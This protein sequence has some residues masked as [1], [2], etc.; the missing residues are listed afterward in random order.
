MIQRHQYAH[1]GVT[2]KADALDR[3]Q[4]WAMTTPVL[5]P[6]YF[7]HFLPKFDNLSEERLVGPLVDADPSA[8]LV[9]SKKH[10]GSLVMA[11]PFFSKNGCGNVYSRMGAV[12]LREHFRAVWGAVDADDVAS[13]AERGEAQFQAWWADSEARGLCYSFEIVV[14]R[15]LGDHGATPAGAFAI[16]TAVA[17]TRE[18]R[19]LSPLEMIRLATK[20]R[21]PLD[22]AWYVPAGEAAAV[23]HRLRDARWV[24][25]DE[26]VAEIMR[27][28]RG[29][30]SQGFLPHGVVQGPVLEGFVLMALS[31]QAPTAPA[32]AAAAAAAASG[33]SPRA[34]GEQSLDYLRQLLDE[35][36]RA[37]GGTRARACAAALA[38]GAR[39]LAAEPALVRLLNEPIA[40]CSEPT[41]VSRGG[42]SGE[43]A[44]W[45]RLNPARAPGS[46]GATPLC[47]L[48]GTL[49]SVYA[50][51]ITTKEYRY[52]G[53]TLVQIQ[54]A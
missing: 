11:P 47:R 9:V 2:V 14:P 21:L 25:R 40:G 18:E 29:A 41:R 27:S 36:E 38:L 15:L 34:R 3:T 24:L 5:L 4:T 20:W 32:T 42:D 8:F 13:A 6:R 30:L 43:A 16:L 52:K 53:I 48:L 31:V 10:S 12:V 51:R 44:L 17:S 26:G 45:R 46:L 39:C 7:A 23:E 54:G 22:E 35:Y 28:A 1:I 19:L 50:Q 49:E 33:A 37:V